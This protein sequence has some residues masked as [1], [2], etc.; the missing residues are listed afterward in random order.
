MKGIYGKEQALMAYLVIVCLATMADMLGDIFLK[1][2]PHE[3]KNNIKENKEHMLRQIIKVIFGMAIMLATLAIMLKYCFFVFAFM[4]ILMFLIVTPCVIGD[5]IRYLFGKTYGYK[6]TT[7]TE[8]A[9]LLCG[10]F[11]WFVCA[12]I[13]SEETSKEILQVSHNIIFS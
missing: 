13:A 6:M 9:M 4:A 8:R 2:A 3:G 11:T 10:L 5:F 12:F 7:K 1:S